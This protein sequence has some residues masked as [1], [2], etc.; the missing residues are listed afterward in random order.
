MG[1]RQPNDGDLQHAMN[2]WQTIQNP[3]LRF[4]EV[5][6]GDLLAEQVIVHPPDNDLRELF[7]FVVQQQ[8]ANAMLSQD[9]FWGHYPPVG[10]LPSLTAGRIPFLTMPTGDVLSTD[11]PGL[12]KNILVV[13]PT[14][15]G[16]ECDVRW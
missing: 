9:V 12:T 2:V 11:I 14:G 8:A 5:P 4:H 16:K 13:G 10:E 3:L 6:A 15:G 7:N 1:M